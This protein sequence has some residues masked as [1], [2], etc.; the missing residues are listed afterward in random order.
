MDYTNYN[1]KKAKQNNNAFM[2]FKYFVL[3]EDRHLCGRG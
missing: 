2:A 1:R 3:N